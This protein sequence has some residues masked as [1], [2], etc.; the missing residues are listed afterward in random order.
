MFAGGA[1]AEIASGEQNSCTLKAGLIEGVVWILSAVIFEGVFT[2][3]VEGDAAQESS[4][5]DAI[6]IDVI[7][8]E[9]NSGSGDGANFAGGHVV[10]SAED[11]LSVSIGGR[12][13]ILAA[14]RILTCSWGWNQSAGS[15]IQQC[16][17]CWC[18][19]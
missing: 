7:E 18:F 6:G 12:G 17:A 19:G 14:E 5:D 15:R 2:E 13:Q 8:Q 3:S 9:R 4:G 1:A 10:D 16:L 11:L